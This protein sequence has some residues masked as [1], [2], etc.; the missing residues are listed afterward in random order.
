MKGIKPSPKNVGE[1]MAEAGFGGG[2]SLKV[3]KQ[4]LCG[5]MMGFYGKIC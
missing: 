4:M 3:G 2:G 1:R 5:L